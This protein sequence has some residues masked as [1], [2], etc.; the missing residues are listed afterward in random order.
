MKMSLTEFRATLMDCANSQTSWDENAIEAFYQSVIS[1]PKKSKRS[2]SIEQNDKIPPGYRCIKCGKAFSACG[3][4]FH[5]TD[6]GK[7]R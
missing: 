3:C 5:G 6:Y 4:H 2:V 1:K 7:K